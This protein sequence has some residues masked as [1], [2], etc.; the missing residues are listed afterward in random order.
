VTT[1]ADVEDALLRALR[2]IRTCW[3]VD[4][5]RLTAGATGP[6]STDEVTT[7]DRWVSL[8]HEV[9]LT[10]NGWARVIV[11]D[12]DLSKAIPDGRDTLGLIDLLE[13]HAR[14]FSG[15]EAVGDAVGELEDA[16]MR[17]RAIAFPQRREWVNLGDCPLEWP[18]PEGIGRVCGGQV[19]AYPTPEDA[20]LGEGVMRLP[21]CQQCG[22]EA[23]VEWWETHM[24]PDAETRRLLTAEGVVTFVHSQYGEAIERCTVRKWVARG[25]LW[26]DGTDDK[27]RALYDREHVV[28]AMRKRERMRASATL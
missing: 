13:R 2:T 6:R 25:I 24:F 17:L 26:Q 19:R 23:S 20:R 7:L 1:T 12:R 9:H 18:D 21:T 5:T 10:L 3:R 4:Y 22:T 14:W 8:R 11:E 28:L 27:G 15:H 16:A